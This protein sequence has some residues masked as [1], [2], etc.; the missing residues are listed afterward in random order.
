MMVEELRNHC[1]TP[2]GFKPPHQTVQFA[3]IGIPWSFK[4]LKISISTV[5]AILSFS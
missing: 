3:F 4:S 2:S 1:D 5:C